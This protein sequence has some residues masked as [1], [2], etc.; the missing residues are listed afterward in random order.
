[1][2][3]NPVAK[4]ASTQTVQ[5][6]DRTWPDR[7]IGKA[8]IWCSVDLRDG[9]QA[10]ID[11]MDL[12]RKNRMF[13]LLVGLGFKEI[14]VGFPA[15]SETEFDF[16]R[17]LIEQGRIPQDV[18]VQVLTQAREELIQRTFE[19]LRGVHR[20]IVHVYNSTSTVQREVVFKMDRGGVKQLAVDGARMLKD[21]AA[22]HPGTEWI[23]EY[24]PESF[25]GTELDYALEV[26]EAVL[27]V[28]K[29]TPERRAI[30]NLPATVEN[31]H[32]ECLCGSDRVDRTELQGPGFDCPE[33]ASA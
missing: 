22:L 19:A 6:K 29:P 4:Y 13:D 18:T 14:E 20:A 17:G 2:L 1:M 16:C 27:D 30:I 3:K 33:R 24:S 9:N 15:A 31:S 23:F 8:P 26:C 7:P 21:Q 25:T 10:L 5:L 28:W 32:A 11:P 12:D